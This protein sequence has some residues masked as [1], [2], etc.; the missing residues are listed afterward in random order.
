M[1]FSKCGLGRDYIMER[2]SEDVRWGREALGH[3]PEHKTAELNG[4]YHSAA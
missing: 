2:E 1:V 4:D 3:R